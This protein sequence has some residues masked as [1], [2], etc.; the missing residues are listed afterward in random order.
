MHIYVTLKYNDFW[1]TLQDNCLRLDIHNKNQILACGSAEYN[2]PIEKCKNRILCPKLK[3]MNT[4][5][6]ICLTAPETGD[7]RFIFQPIFHNKNL[8]LIRKGKKR[9]FLQEDF[10]FERKSKLAVKT[11]FEGPK[12][13]SYDKFKETCQ[14]ELFFYWKNH[15][16]TSSV[17]V[18]NIQYQL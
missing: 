7:N 11:C 8:Q 16:Q 4:I 14:R 6:E 18:S 9:C 15:L 1:T 12:F 10:D 13:I 3:A 2:R 17:P 5:M